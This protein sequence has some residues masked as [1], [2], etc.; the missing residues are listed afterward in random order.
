MEF[1]EYLSLLL[2]S[3]NGII[4]IISDQKNM[5]YRVSSLGSLLIL[6]LMR[7]ATIV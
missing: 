7:Q 4:M 5:F 1:V 6:Y 3:L 2:R